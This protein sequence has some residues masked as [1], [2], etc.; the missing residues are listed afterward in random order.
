MS[1]EPRRVTSRRAVRHGDA[2]VLRLDAAA[3]ARVGAAIRSA[4]TV[5]HG[6]HLNARS[7]RVRR[8]AA[9]R[10]ELAALGRRVLGCS[11]RRGLPPRRRS[12]KYRDANGVRRV[13]RS[14]ARR[15]SSSSRQRRSSARFEK[16]EVKLLARATTASGVDAVSRRTPT[17]RP[18]SSLFASTTTDERR[19]RHAARGLADAA[20]RAAMPSS[21]T[22]GKDRRA[23]RS[24]STTSSSTYPATRARSIGPSSRTACRTRLSSSL[25]VSQAFPDTTTHTRPVEPATPIDFVMPVGTER[26]RG[27]RRHVIE[28]ASDFHEIG[29]ERRDRRPARE[30]RARAARRRHDGAVRAPELEL[31]PRR[32]G[33]ARRARRVSRGLRQHGLQHRAAPALRRAAQPRRRDRV[34]A[35]SV[36]GR[37]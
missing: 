28:V 37:R 17:T 12:I 35:A 11:R 19:R 18:C 9:A 2:R 4:G 13:H 32:A 1:R 10:H 23:R 33:P 24:A 21:S 20:A 29:A 34:A 14:A 25:A 6:G 36:R 16:P 31:D 22:C 7:H 30:R 3:R 5:A 26:V 8:T 15:P 27:A